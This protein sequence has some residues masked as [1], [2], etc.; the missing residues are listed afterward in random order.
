M[1]EILAFLH[2]KLENF[3]TF[4]GRRHQDLPKD[5]LWPQK[6]RVRNRLYLYIDDGFATLLGA[7]LHHDGGER[8]GGGEHNVHADFSGKFNL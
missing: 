7:F 8:E 6:R 1:L 3:H 4:S 5:L 2:I